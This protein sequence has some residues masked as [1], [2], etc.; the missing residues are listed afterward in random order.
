MFNLFFRRYLPGFRVGPDGVPGFNIDDY[1]LPQ[2]ATAS[3]DDTLPESA[4]QRY[5]DAAQTQSPP[6]I[7]FRLPGAEGWVLSAPLIGSPGFRVSPQDDVLGFNVGPQ[8]DAPGFNLDE[9][10]GQQ[11]ETTRSDGLRPGSMTP[12]DLN[13]PQTPTPPPGEKDPV[14]PAPPQ[15]PEWLYKLVTML[16]PRLS[17]TFDPRTGPP[18]AI[19]SPPG[20]GLAA[21]P[22]ADQWPPA[23]AP[24][25]PADIDIRSRAA[26]TQNTNPQPA[27]QQAMRNPWLQPLKGGWPYAQGDGALPP[28]PSVQ[29]PADSN[30]SLA[31]ADDAGEQQTQ[32]QM[33]LQHYQQTQRTMPSVPLGTGPAMV[34]MPQEP[35]MKMTELEPRSEQEFSQLIEAYRRLKETEGRQPISDQPLPQP[36]LNENGASSYASGND[37]PSLGQRLAQSSVETLV[38][39]A[40]Y[41][42][43]ARQQLGAGN[44]VGAGVYQAA[45]L[46]DAALGVATLGLGTRLAAA[47]RTAAAEG[48][49]LFRRAFDSRSQLLRYL[50]RAPEGMQWHHIVEQSQAAQFGQRPIQSV[51]N[52]VALPIEA[53]QELNAFYSSKQQISVPNTVRE[54]LRGQS[55]EVQYEFGMEQL[56][57]VLG[58]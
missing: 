37:G 47:G 51:E 55:F 13:A 8:D 28:I 11:Q 46:V 1:G 19:N 20:L 32:Q 58:D 33:P 57:R 25:Q 4:A 42:E 43:L 39:G 14:P 38:P 7:S 41:Q 9:N 34:H 40:H 21:A 17:T 56:K 6:S 12:Q 30:F 22:G 16:P 27:A 50:G 31:N 3:F 49:A 36:P 5:P 53:H 23:S 29:P 2:R 15:L 10:S 48:A 18:I 54:W 45:A 52:I 26:T 35:G 44:Y 24:Q